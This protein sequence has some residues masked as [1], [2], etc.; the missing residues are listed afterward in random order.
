MGAKST[1]QYNQ[2]AAA[3]GA[4]QMVPVRKGYLFSANF[5]SRLDAQAEAYWT[6][7]VPIM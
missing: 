5:E 3:L 7:V 4:L 2:V 6:G 1:V